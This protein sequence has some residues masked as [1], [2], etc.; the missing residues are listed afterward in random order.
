LE[1]QEELGLNV[2]PRALQK[3]FKIFAC[4]Q[5]GWEFVWAAVSKETIDHR[6]A[7]PNSSIEHSGPSP[8]A[9]VARTL[10]GGSPSLNASSANTQLAT[11]AVS[12]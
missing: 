6:L 1:L 8:L 7:R 9:D 2:V 11:H 3:L 4:A 12:A 5:T 10:T